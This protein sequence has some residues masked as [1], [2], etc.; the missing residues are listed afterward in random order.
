MNRG[1]FRNQN[2]GVIMGGVSSERAVSLKTGEAVA[3]ALENL[4]YSIVRIDAGTDLPAQIRA[5]EVDVV[6]NALHGVFGEDGRVQGLLDWMAIPYTGEG[7]RSSL[8]GFDK[9]LAKDSYRAFGV[10][11]ARDF[12]L[13][14]IPPEA[15][16]LERIELDFPV[17]VKPVSE[18]SSVGV[19]RVDSRAE[20]MGA[21]LESDVV[22][23]LI[24][25]WITGPEVSV[26]CLGAD[27]LGSVEIVPGDGFYDYEAKYGNGGTEYF[28]P[29][30]LPE[31]EIARCEEAGLQAHRALGC[32]AVTRSDVILGPNGPVVLETNTL[33]GMTASSLVPKVAA[34]LGWSFEYLVERILDLASFEDLGR[35]AEGL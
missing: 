30:R 23:L 1:R 16:D 4:G 10:P 11:V 8:L 27:A 28:V 33:P 25:E 21:L 31:N 18:G 32:T 7:Q 14:T 24:E 12:I 3:L 22:P 5:N 26:V 20:L 35:K 17:V 34:S 29:P 13:D 19:R 2:V 9:S 15:S 6:F